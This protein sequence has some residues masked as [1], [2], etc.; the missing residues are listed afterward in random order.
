[1]QFGERIK[2]IENKY[3]DVIELYKFTQF[4]IAKQNEET[5]KFAKNTELK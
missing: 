5:R 4:V 3:A 1:M 2:E